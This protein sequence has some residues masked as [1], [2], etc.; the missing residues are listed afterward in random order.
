MSNIK[1]KNK[2]GI[3]GKCRIVTFKAGTKIV[4]RKSNWNGNLVVS[5]T[6]HGLNLILKH[7]IGV[8][9]YPLEITQGKIGDD[10]TAATDNDTD[11]G[12][13]IVSDIAVATITE[14]TT[15]QITIEFFISD[16]ELAEDTYEEFG[17]FAGDQ[18][19]A[20]S[21]IDPAYVKSVGE[22]TK[23]EY[24]INLSNT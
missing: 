16:A 12:N 2:Q 14:T 17:I 20:R 11:L 6:N 22:D 13:A 18:L 1:I 4:L 7:L 15:S 23:I 24:V 21:I 5:N 9:T 10:S 8:T 19:F 3:T